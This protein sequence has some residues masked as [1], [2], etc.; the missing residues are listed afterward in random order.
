MKKLNLLLVGLLVLFTCKNTYA[1]YVPTLEDLLVNDV[2]G[3]FETPIK[4]THKSTSAY[5]FY[6]NLRTWIPYR[7]S[8]PLKNPPITYIEVS[9]HVFLDDNG[10]NSNYTNTLAGK[11]DF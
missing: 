3:D 10:G 11:I 1:Q 9:F 5:D 7:N 2:L 8:E 4:N 6:N